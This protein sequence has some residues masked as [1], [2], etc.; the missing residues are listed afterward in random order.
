MEND[1]KEQYIREMWA[2]FCCERPRIKN[3]ERMLRKKGKQECRASG[4]M[5]RQP[6]STWSK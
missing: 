2:Y 4:S 5:N 1:G 3:S 6:G